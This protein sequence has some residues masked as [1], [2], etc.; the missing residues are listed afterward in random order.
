MNVLL[1]LLLDLSVCC[2]LKPE[3]SYRTMFSI[4][5]EEDSG[6]N[7]AHAQGQSSVPNGEN[8]CPLS[9]LSVYLHWI[10][11]LIVT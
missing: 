6:G 4:H 3:Q 8:L 2:V 7:M 9:C 5:Q 1:L 10:I 11:L